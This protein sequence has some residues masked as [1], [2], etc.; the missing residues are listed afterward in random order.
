MS[1][2]RSSAA[3]AVT[4]NTTGSTGSYAR[5]T[6]QAADWLSVGKTRLELLVVELEEE[7]LRLMLVAGKGLLA[8]FAL[9][10]ASVLAV[11]TLA[12]AF[13]AAR[14]LIFSL[15]TLFFFAVTLYLCLSIRRQMKQPSA[16]CRASLDC[17]S[18]DIAELRAL[19]AT[20]STQ[21][22]PKRP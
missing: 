12:A 22:S 11:L 20:Q 10:M 6:N 16:L 5:L 9:F 17:L 3:D 18:D 19:A 7:K 8:A 4:G 14:L 15:A 21:A 2:N 13:P 1:D